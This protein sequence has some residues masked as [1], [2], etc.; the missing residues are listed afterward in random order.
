MHYTTMPH[1]GYRIIV[2]LKVNNNYGLLDGQVFLK[3]N[4]C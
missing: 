1:K 3:C 4:S 2:K